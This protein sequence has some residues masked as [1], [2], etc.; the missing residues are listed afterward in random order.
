LG[1]MPFIDL[2]LFFDLKSYAEKIDTLIR[3]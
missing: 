1:V 2:S 3:R